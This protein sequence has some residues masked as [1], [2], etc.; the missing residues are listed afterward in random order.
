MYQP[1]EIWLPVN[2][3]ELW[4][5]NPALHILHNIFEKI[6]YRGKRMIGLNIGA[7]FTI[8][9]I[10]TAVTTSAIALSQ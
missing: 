10:I 1:T 5:Q 4:E 3:T 9:G 7:I 2:F 6:F 8:I